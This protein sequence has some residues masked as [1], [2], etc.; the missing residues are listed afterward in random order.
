MPEPR[1]FWLAGAAALLLALALLGGGARAQSLFEKL[2]MPGQVIRGHAKLEKD[3]NNCHVPFARQSQSDKC[4]DC[5]KEVAADRRS[6]K[7]F[8]GRNAQASRSDCRHCHG[9]HKGRDADVV[10]LDS[11]TFNHAFTNF[12][13]E[14]AHKSVQCG[15]CHAKGSKFR[16]APN[17]CV[18]CHK[19]IDP[20]KGRLGDKCASCHAVADGWRKTRIFDHERTKFPLKDAHAKVKCQACHTGERYKD[21]ATQCVACHR[22]QDVHKGRYGAKCESC[23]APRKWTEVHFDHGKTRFPLRGGHAKA[24]CDKCHSGNLFTDK[25]E[26]ACAACHKKDDPHKGQLGERCETCH[27]DLGWR[28][29]TA[30]DHDLTRFPLIGLHAAV[31]CEECHVSTSYKG[32][33]RA[34]RACHK[35]DHHRGRLGTD[36]AACHN[37]N[38]WAFW[39]FDHD[40]QTKYPLAGSHRGLECAACHTRESVAK[41]VAPRQCHACH[42]ADDAHRGTFG[43]ACDKCHTTTRFR[44]TR[45]IR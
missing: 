40:R 38:G 32:T 26:T 18:D 36:C 21:L 27:N 33:E 22:I 23:H 11:E 24:K 8:H 29:K 44:Q 14:G 28:K 2:V 5:H 34:C 3:C 43:R 42:A 13:L 16:K 6:E 35:D 39:R 1:T 31:P 10:G 19:K 25:L 17:A 45:I 4:L 41:A 15:S 7:G 12:A 9:D 20:H 30:F 37:P